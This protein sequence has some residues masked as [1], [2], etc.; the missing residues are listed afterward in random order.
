MVLPGAELATS[1]Y[2]NQ[3]NAGAHFGFFKMRARKPLTLVMG[4]KASGSR[5]RIHPSH[6]SGNFSEKLVCKQMFLC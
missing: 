3:K 5:G 2:S 4:M 1:E 6:K